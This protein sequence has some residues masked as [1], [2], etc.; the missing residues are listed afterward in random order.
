[1]LNLV[2]EQADPEEFEQD[3][4]LKLFSF[5][6]KNFGKT[7]GESPD[8]IL[9]MTFGKS[10][11][12]PTGLSGGIVTSSNLPKQHMVDNLLQNC[13]GRPQA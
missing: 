6:F 8:S 12:F 13:Q 11:L 4:I 9:V 3:G 10:I 2:V 1:M 7:Y 5:T